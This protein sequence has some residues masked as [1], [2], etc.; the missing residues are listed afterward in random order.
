M[1]HRGWFLVSVADAML[2]QQVMG[3]VRAYGV[4][5]CEP[6]GQAGVDQLAQSQRWAGCIVEASSTNLSLL[7][8]L[9][10]RAPTLPILVVMRAGDP[11]L[12]N[13]LQGLGIE[14]VVTPVPDPNLVSFVQRAFAMGFL[15]D[16]RVARMVTHVAVERMLTAREVQIL[17]FGLGNEPRERVRRRLGITENTLKTQTRALLRKCGERS[18]DTLAKNVLRAALLAEKPPSSSV[19][20]VAPWLVTAKSA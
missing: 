12:M 6:L 1:F 7:A 20:P 16:E 17:S 13:R 9:R 11:V 18:V 10:K 4:A 14:A 5:C 19:Q 3:I 15:P 2:A 8:A